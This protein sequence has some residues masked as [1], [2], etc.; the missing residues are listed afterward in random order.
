M[1]LARIAIDRP[2][3]TFMLY[4]AVA[5]FGFISLSR[6][7]IDLLPE[8]NFPRLSVVTQYP[9]VAPEGI[10]TLITAPLEA[11]VS[12]VPGIRRVESISREGISHLILEFS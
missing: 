7:S 6:L 2:V 8:I 12:R 9:G 10:E 3:T 4:I 1:K 11:A 5:L